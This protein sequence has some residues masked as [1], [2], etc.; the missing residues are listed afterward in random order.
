M[1]GSRVADYE[2]IVRTYRKLRVQ[3]GTEPSE[4]CPGL[5]ALVAEFTHNRFALGAWFFC[6]S[7]AE[8]PVLF[9]ALLRGIPPAEGDTEVREDCR[10]YLLGIP[11]RERDFTCDRQ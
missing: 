4:S 3:I 7:T 8:A 11:R 6:A 1:V 2:N 9:G 10:G 5:V